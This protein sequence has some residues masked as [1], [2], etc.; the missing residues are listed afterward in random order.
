MDSRLVRLVSVVPI[1][2]SSQVDD[3]DHLPD[4]GLDEAIL[5]TDYQDGPG[6]DITVIVG[7]EIHDLL[8]GVSHTERVELSTHKREIWLDES[9]RQVKARPRFQPT[10]EVQNPTRGRF[11]TRPAMSR[12][13]PVAFCFSAAAFGQTAIELQVTASEAT[14][15]AGEEKKQHG[16]LSWC[17]IE[18]LKEL[19]NN[20]TYLELLKGI[21]RQLAK[22]REEVPKLDQETLL[23]FTPPLSEPTKMRV[24][25]PMQVK[26]PA[27]P[28]GSLTVAPPVVP[29]PPPGFISSSPQRSFKGVPSSPGKSRPLRECTA[30]ISPQR[31]TS[32]PVVLGLGVE[33]VK[34]RKQLEMKEQV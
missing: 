9:S 7:T 23:T 20:C 24:L 12:A 31:F 1:D 15:S 11:P 22:M 33:H 32:V 30:P 10:M 13:N 14:W 17:F 28:S 5:P 16:V 26:P 34:S 25:Q 27:R 19:R 2:C 18:A 6:N 8:G 29:P 21:Q 4:D 3:V